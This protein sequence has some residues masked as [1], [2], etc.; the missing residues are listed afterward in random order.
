MDTFFGGLKSG[1]VVTG[2]Q[3]GA[4]SLPE[5]DCH[6]PEDDNA[7]QDAPQVEANSSEVVFGLECEQGQG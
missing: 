3:D 5:V 1:S 4:V 6:D 2:M 7:P